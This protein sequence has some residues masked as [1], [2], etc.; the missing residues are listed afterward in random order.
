MDLVKWADRISSVLLL[1]VCAWLMVLSRR[2]SPYSALFPRT[3][4]VI[5]AVLSAVLLALSFLKPSTARVYPDFR[6]GTVPIAICVG[7]M[8][9]WVVFIDLLGFLV[10]TLVFF[11]LTTLFLSRKRHAAAL[12]G[13][14]ALVSALSIGFYLFFARLLSVPFP[15][16]LLL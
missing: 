12:A 5:L 11:S 15:T 9:G 6:R 7:L 1:G 2:F 16:G 8:I 14:V 3:I 10:A 13:N 4:L